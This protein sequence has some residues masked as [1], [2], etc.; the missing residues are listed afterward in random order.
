[1]LDGSSSSSKSGSQNRALA[2][3]RRIRQPPEN[4][5]VANCWRSGEKPRPAKILAAL[6]SALS[7]SISA[8]LD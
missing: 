8:N 2:S 1:M 4:V 5:L 6:D 3:A 7:D